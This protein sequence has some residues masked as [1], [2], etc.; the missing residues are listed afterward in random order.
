MKKGKVKKERLDEIQRV[1]RSMGLE[2]EEVRKYLVGL[3]NWPKQPEQERPIVFIEAGI[4][5]YSQGE[6]ESAGLE[7]TSE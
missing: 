1:Y 6:M 5:S 3:G 4:A 7:P 2:S